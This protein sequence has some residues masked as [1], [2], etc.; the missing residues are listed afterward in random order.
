LSL[1]NSNSPDSGHIA[2]KLVRGDLYLHVSACGHLTGLR[3]QCMTEAVAIT[4]M[5]PATDFNVIK[6]RRGATVVSLLQYSRFFSDPFPTLF[7]SVTVD[8]INRSFKSRLYN[9]ARNPP[10]LHKKELLLGQEHP[11]RSLFE[12]LTE[13]LEMRNIKPDKPGL[14]FKKQWDAYLDRMSIVVERHMI[15]D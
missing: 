1:L 8:I 2:G 3:L 10:I 4:G 9:Q 11:K 6:I 14:G 7:T 15:A 12:K 5:S 13:S